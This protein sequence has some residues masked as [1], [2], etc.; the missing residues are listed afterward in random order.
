MR[1]TSLISLSIV[2]SMRWYHITNPNVD[3]IRT[4]IY[5]MYNVIYV[6]YA[7][8]RRLELPH[9]SNRVSVFRGNRAYTCGSGYV[10][11]TKSV[12]E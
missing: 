9:N 6:D 11:A 2:L 4:E 12:I 8:A 5:F 3:E 10:H 1:D 7:V